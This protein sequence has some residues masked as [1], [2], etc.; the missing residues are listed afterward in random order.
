[1]SLAFTIVPFFIRR[2]NPISRGGSEDPPLLAAVN[3]YPVETGL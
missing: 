3:G 2:L 1:M